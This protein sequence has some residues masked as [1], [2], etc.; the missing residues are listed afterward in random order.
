M[1]LMLKSPGSVAIDWARGRASRRRPCED[2]PLSTGSA[3]VPL[4]NSKDFL[5][6]FAKGVMPWVPLGHGLGGPGQWNSNG[7][8][9][10]PSLCY[11]LYH[12]RQVL[13]LAMEPLDV[14]PS[15]A[16]AAFNSGCLQ[17]RME[18]TFPLFASPTLELPVARATGPLA[19]SIH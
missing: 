9:S 6:F 11:T 12:T 7:F 4:D 13:C 1:I 10:P 14:L 18:L 3:R 5:Q 15:A 16:S 19:L 17:R 2:T 8:A